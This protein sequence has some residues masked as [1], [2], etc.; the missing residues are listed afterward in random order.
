MPCRQRHRLLQQR[1]RPNR[2]RWREG[3]PQRRCRCSSEC[4][5]G[6]VCARR[7]T[8][9]R[10]SVCRHPVRC[11][12]VLVPSCCSWCRSC[13][14]S[15][16]STL[17]SAPCS[18]VLV[19]VSPRSSDSP[20]SLPRSVRSHCSSVPRSTVRPSRVCTWNGTRVV[21]PQ[22]CCCWVSPLS[23]RCSGCAAS[24]F[25]ERHHVRCRSVSCRGLPQHRRSVC[26]DR[27][28]RPRSRR[29]VRSARV[30]GEEAPGGARDVPGALRCRRGEVRSRAR[31]GPL[32]H[33]TTPNQP[34]CRDHV[35]RGSGA[36]TKTKSA[37][38][39]LRS[40]LVSFVEGPVRRSLRAFRGG[41]A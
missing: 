21:S 25:A 32:R 33:A 12:G 27:R 36:G 4:L 38:L 10:R 13:C 41:C 28:G 6:A 39:R 20:V 29:S 9:S 14:V 23:A 19:S 37:T 35:E 11:A 18:P 40:C 31:S 3:L 24:R 2:Q 17:C 5:T 7:S 22:V 15:S 30:R 26:R 1:R 34:G 8:V 16:A